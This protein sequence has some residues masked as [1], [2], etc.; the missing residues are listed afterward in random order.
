MA[1]R[2]AEPVGAVPLEEQPARVP[3]LARCEFDGT[4]DLQWAGLNDYSTP[5]TPTGVAR[6]L[7]NRFSK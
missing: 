7:V 5:A 1:D 4:G 6:S 2:F 3:V